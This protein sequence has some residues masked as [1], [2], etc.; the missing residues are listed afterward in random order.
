M[1]KF[2]RKIFLIDFVLTMIKSKQNPHLRFAGFLQVFSFL[3]LILAVLLLI[4]A[5]NGEI[6]SLAGVACCTGFFFFYR[7]VSKILKTYTEEEAAKFGYLRYLNPVA[8]V[9]YITTLVLIFLLILN[10]IMLFFMIMGTLLFFLIIL[11][12]F[13]LVLLDKTFRLN[14]FI[15]VP[16]DFFRAEDYFLHHIVGPEIIIGFLLLIY[17]LVPISAS[18]MILLQHYS[19]VAKKV[20]S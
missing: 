16:R 15:S 9:I 12:T 3:W 8:P 14:N 10:A 2:L 7:Y 13:G 19:E 6:Q 11:V 17:F 20:K 18:V 4:N 1:V 5:F